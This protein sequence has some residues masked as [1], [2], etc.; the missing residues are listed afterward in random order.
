MTNKYA[1]E[2]LYTSFNIREPQERSDLYH[3][4]GLTDNTT[5]SMP[6]YNCSNND[7]WGQETGTILFNSVTGK[8]FRANQF[9]DSSNTS[10][11]FTLDQ[12][13]QT[14][15]ARLSPSNTSVEVYSN[16]CILLRAFSYI[17]PTD[18]VTKYLVAGSNL[19]WR[20]ASEMNSTG[21]F[22][23]EVY[24]PLYLRSTGTTYI[25]LESVG[26]V[27]GSFE[28][29]YDGINF[30]SYTLGTEKQVNDGERIFFRGTRS[31]VQNSNNYLHFIIT[32]TGTA[33]AYG[34]INSLAYKNNYVST[35]FTQQNYSCYKLFSSCSKL[36]RAPLLP[37]T[38]L[39]TSCY[40]SMFEDCTSLAEAPQLP[41]TTL[42]NRC[43]FG[44][45]SGCTSLTRSPDLPATTPVTGCYDNM[46]NG[47]TSLDTLYCDINT[48]TSVNNFTFSSVTFTD[49]LSGVSSSGKLYCTHPIIY[50][51][52]S[53]S[54]IPSGWDP[55]CI[56]SQPILIGAN[57]H[58][59][60][61]EYWWM[62]GCSSE[63]VSQET[64]K[65]YEP[66]HHSHLLETIATSNTTVEADGDY[67][68]YIPYV[69]LAIDSEQISSEDTEIDI[70]AYI[71][72]NL[73]AME[74]FIPYEQYRDPSIPTVIGA[75]GDETGLMNTMSGLPDNEYS[76]TY[77]GN[78]AKI[79]WTNNSIFNGLY[80]CISK[81]YDG[82]LGW[83]MSDYVTIRSSSTNDTYELYNTYMN[84]VEIPKQNAESSST[85][86]ITALYDEY[87]NLIP[88][89]KYNGTL[90]IRVDGSVISL[91][92]ARARTEDLN[93][94][95]VSFVRVN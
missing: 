93:V 67:G 62:T 4:Y 44:M 86:R 94:Y 35:T 56:I 32:G 15:S 70:R 83:D 26:T 42:A 84:D 51:R 85:F 39:S 40:E 9:V 89:S 53:T 57:D 25:T 69:K 1:S 7:S 12:L 48:V 71:D 37:Y 72:N 21:F 46:F 29:S 58:S 17:D 54:G 14:T 65:A 52:D 28:F 36:T 27:S 90:V 16:S 45:F 3:K 91:F 61:S 20:T 11:W 60:R 47:C 80:C 88:L 19:H 49:W 66:S 78:Y 76:L 75:Y 8:Y 63:E 2:D 74:V 95:K 79:A 38:K 41:A 50:T 92:T 82:Y 23:E 64:F 24:A 13:S 81:E 34:N 87:G 77:Y 73:P 22:F 30:S 18:N 10:R 31:T 68:G 33:A 59:A 55:Y 6:A 43:Y 5:Q